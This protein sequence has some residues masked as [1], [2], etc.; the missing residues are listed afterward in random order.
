MSK[1]RLWYI[2][3]TLGIHLVRLWFPWSGF[4]I[5]SPAHLLLSGTHTRPYEFS[6]WWSIIFSVGDLSGILTRCS[7]PTPAYTTAGPHR[8][9]Q[10]MA[11]ADHLL[12]IV[13]QNI[14]SS[15]A[16]STW[17]SYN[18]VWNMYCQFSARVLQRPPMLPIHS[19]DLLYFIAHLCN[20]GL[21]A[22]TISGQHFSPF[23]IA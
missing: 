12:S 10:P 20:Q 5:S 9:L 21:S 13:I 16:P 4:C 7:I 15:R 8:H 1:T 6:C 19:I 2:T 22:A 3:S 17:I 18:R 14:R 23:I 11:G